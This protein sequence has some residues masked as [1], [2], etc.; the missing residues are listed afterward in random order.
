M[1]LPERTKQN[2]S[3]CQELA[4]YLPHSC[5]DPESSIPAFVLQ[6]L[7]PDGKMTPSVCARIMDFTQKEKK[8]KEVCD[9]SR[10]KVRPDDGRIYILIKRKTISSTNY[11]DLIDKLYEHYFGIQK[12]SLEDFFE[13]WMDWRENIY[14]LIKRKTISSTNYPDL[15]DKLYEHYFGIQKI[16]LEDF[17]EIW[18][19]WR[20]KETSVTP[21]TRKENRFIWNSLLKD[22]ELAKQPLKEI[23]VLDYINFFRHITKDRTLTRKRFND[24]K[25]ILNGMLYLAVEKGIISH[26][27]LNDINYKQFA[28]KVEQNNCRP[29]TEAEREQIIKYLS[30]LAVEKGIISHNCLNDINYKQFAY[31]VEQ[32]NC[33]PYTEAEREQ[34]IKYLSGKDDF[35]SMA[36][37][38]D[39]YLV[40]RIGE[41]KGLKW[42]DISNGY[43]HISRFVNDKNE[44]VN[45]I[46]GHTSEGI[47]YLVLRIGEL[48]GL[49]WSDISNG[50]IHISRFVNDKNE[51]VNEIK[52]HTSEGIRTMPLTPGA[53]AVLEKIYRLHFNSSDYIFFR[54]GKPL[55]TVTFNRHLKKCCE[56]LNIEYRSSHKLRFSTASIMYK[57][58]VSD[59]ELQKL[60]GHTTL[61]MT[62]HYLKNI[63]SEQETANKMAAITASIM[64]KNGV[65]DTELQKL[66]GHTTLTMTQHYL[67][68]I[69][70]EQETANK[71]AAIL[72]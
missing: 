62:Q 11:P 38:L 68:N 1:A 27:C 17:F 51:V 12:I 8:V 28:Y 6:I 33:R 45:E 4:A 50:Y 35:Y 5:D 65:S 69:V 46:K 30:G 61:T 47:F 15:I 32:N 16:S 48:K 26:N 49:K 54:D 29:Y 18:M 44:V 19:D 23:Q 59:T 9:L 56:E 53:Q 39:F 55:A 52:G 2:I 7:C 67:K 58:G 64:Y 71:M 63:V 13:I 66:L 41:L 25:S 37:L 72:G 42:S 22:T 3:I 36:I 24:M 43:I 20:E 60:L 21:K 40:L 14:I 31:K 70:S 34:I 57:N 10:L